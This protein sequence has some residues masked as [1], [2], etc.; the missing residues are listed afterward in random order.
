MAIGNSGNYS[1]VNYQ[2]KLKSTSSKTMHNL[3]DSLKLHQK[4]SQWKQKDL[5]QSIKFQIHFVFNSLL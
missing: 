2:D 5:F 3:T 4:H 1:S